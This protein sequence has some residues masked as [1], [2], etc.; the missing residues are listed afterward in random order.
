ML[1]SE[2]RAIFA[3][4]AITLAVLVGGCSDDSP[5]GQQSNVSFQDAYNKDDTWL[6]HWYLCGTDL[7]TRFGSASMDLEELMK[8]KLPPNV[9]VL[10]EAGGAKKWNN[11]YVPNKKTVRLLYDS[12]GIHELGKVKDADMGAPTTLMDFLRYGKENYTAD[13]HVFVFWD[14]GGGSMNGVCYD[15]I[16]GNM[17]SLNDIRQAFESVYTA[18]EEKP[19]FEM[20]G[21]DACLMATY[22]TAHMLQGLT[23]YMVASEEVE[24]GCGWY[25][26]GWIGALAKNTAMGGNGLGKEICDSY[27]EGCRTYDVEDSVTLSVI[28]LSKLPA[29]KLAYDAFGIEALEAAEKHPKKFFSAFVRE[30]KTAENYGGNTKNQ[31]YTNMVDM[32]DLAK[33]TKE[34]LPK[35]YDQLIKAVNDA[36]IYRVNGECRD[37][38][39]GISSFHSYDSDKRHFSL[40]ADQKSASLPHKYLY[41]YLIYGKLPNGIVKDLKTQLA[42]EK[43]ELEAQQQ[44]AAQAAQEENTPTMGLFTIKTLE[45]ISV[46]VDK[47]GNATVKLDEA[48]MD[49]VSAIHCNLVLM[50]LKHDRLVYLGSDGDINA[51]WDKGVFKDNFQG[52]WPMLDGHPIYIEITAMEDDYNLYSIPIKLNGEECNLIV[53]YQFKNQK[54]KILGARQGMDS[55]GMADRNLRKLK[56]GDKVTTI[57]YAM[58]ISG[59]DEDFQ[60]TE[61]ETFTIGDKPQVKDENLADGT[62]G[63]L[64]EFISPN[65]DSALSKLVEFAL[66]KGKITTTVND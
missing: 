42:D 31:G 58:T 12:D 33:E 27:M 30:A 29:L 35:S 3:L 10:I 50:D 39:S 60:P 28:D 53:S 21:F 1:K 36:V 43:K 6:I 38:G 62:Y 17:L 44:M 32:A 19:P 57:H 5:P 8:V 26:T 40:Y 16:T 49:L 48:Q 7:E 14:H 22:E 45:D 51:D 64:F 20:I 13:H 65:G 2:L 55:H 63:Y 66:K 11:S 4:L 34:Q 9:K 46:S 56:K 47:E 18:S 59:N 25:Y 52:T 15:E 23:R 37:Q 54:Y 61:G 24:P 41:Q